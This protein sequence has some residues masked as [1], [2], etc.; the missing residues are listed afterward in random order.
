MLHGSELPLHQ[1]LIHWPSPTPLRSR[2]S[3]TT[4]WTEAHSVPLSTRH[5]DKNPGVGCYFLLL[6]FS[7]NIY[8]YLFVWLCWVLVAACRV[9]G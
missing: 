8:I 6:P 7:F 5:P 2:L 4:P 9:F 3:D 1:N